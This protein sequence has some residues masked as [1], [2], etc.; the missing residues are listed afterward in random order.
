MCLVFIR[1]LASPSATLSAAVVG[2]N[3]RIPKQLAHQEVM[4]VNVILNP[5]YV[6]EAIVTM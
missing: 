2:R 6:A 5:V 1:P 3:S 4:C